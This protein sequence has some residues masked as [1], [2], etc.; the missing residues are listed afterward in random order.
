ML[1]MG[2]IDLIFRINFRDE[3]LEK[4]ANSK[5]KG[6]DDKNGDDRYYKVEELTDIKSLAFL[7]E[8]E[9]VWVFFNV[10]IFIKNSKRAKWCANK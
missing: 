10:T 2:E 8:R 1:A 4:D 9:E 5:K 6:G 7:E 3:D